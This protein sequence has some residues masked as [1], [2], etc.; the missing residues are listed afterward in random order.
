MPLDVRNV[1]AGYGKAIILSSVCLHLGR[2][3]IVCIA[4]PNGAGKSTLLKVI[5]GVLPWQ[6]GQV[7]LFGAAAASGETADD[8][9]NA[10]GIV[11]QVNNVF[12]SLTVHENLLVVLPSNWPRHTRKQAL[13]RIYDRFRDLHAIRGKPGAALSGGERQS[14]AFAMALSRDPKLLLLD[15]PSA[16]LSPLA[17]RAVFE[18][19]VDLKEAGIPILLVEQ[20]VRSAME[21]A[22]RA[23]FLENGRNYLDGDCSALRDDPR[24]R[25]AYL[26]A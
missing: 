6:S 7:S 17:A 11:P 25:K 20:N 21:I 12:P 2:G 24:I 10:L 19:I 23:Y 18:R 22:D 3:E 5:A 13:E 4:G 8:A 14:V 1:T 15:E 16:A 26:G 9:R